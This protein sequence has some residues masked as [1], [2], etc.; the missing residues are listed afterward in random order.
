MRDLFQNITN[1]RWD[2]DSDRI[3]GCTYPASSVS[4]CPCLCSVLAVGAERECVGVTTDVLNADKNEM[5]T[6]DIDPKKHSVH[7]ITTHLWDL[8]Q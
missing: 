6:F 1:I 4:L 2:H 7:Y 5:T 8:L 3:K